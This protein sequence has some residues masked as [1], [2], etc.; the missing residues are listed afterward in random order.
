MKNVSQTENPSGSNE[1]PKQTVLKFETLLVN[2]QDQ[3]AWCFGE[4]IY[5]SVRNPSFVR[6]HFLLQRLE[7]DGLVRNVEVIERTETSWLI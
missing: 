4:L 1:S 7:E 2:E 6:G 3:E 5:D